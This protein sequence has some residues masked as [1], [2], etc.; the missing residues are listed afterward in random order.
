MYVSCS[1]VS[2][3]ET[4]WMVDC[5]APLSMEFSRQQYWSVLPVPSP[6]YLPDPGIELL[7]TTLQMDSLLSE[8]PG[9]PLNGHHMYVCLV[10]QLS[11]T[12][13]GSMYCSPPSSSVHGILQARILEWV[14]MPSFR[15]PFQPRKGSS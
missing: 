2:D 11:L 9:K 15:R 6:G 7:S 12:L 10:A 8:L 3:S 4:P 14:A 1:V 13:C 5:Q